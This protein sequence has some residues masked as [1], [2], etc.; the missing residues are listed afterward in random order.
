MN[1]SVKGL[2]VFKK[3]PPATPKPLVRPRK[4]VATNADYLEFLPASLE[5]IETPVS[6][7]G[8][9]LLWLLCAM[10]AAATIWS[11]IAKLDIYAVASGK[12]QPSGRSKVIQPIDPGRVIN[13]FVKNGSKVNVGDALLELDPT[14][15]KATQTSTAANL[16]AL[17]AEISRRQTE[18]NAIRSATPEPLEI[19]F[20]SKVGRALRLREA[21]LFKAELE[22]YISS[23]E[24]LKAQATQNLATKSRLISSIAAREQS[25]AVLQE[26]VDLKM[27]LLKT[28]AGTRTSALDAK[29]Q[30]SQ[31]LTS[32]A[33]D[34][35]QLLEAEA[36]IVMTERKI[37]ALQKQFIADQADK[38]SVAENKRD[39]IAQDL[40]KAVAK[41]DH[42]RLEA[43]ITGTV[44]QLAVTTVGQ[45][46]A[47][48]QPLLVIV[49]TVDHLEIEAL[50]PNEDVGFVKV[51]Q[52]AIVKIDAFP[53][54][55][56]GTIDGKVI[57][58]SHDSVY[59][60]DAQMGD[61]SSS[62]D[63]NASMLDPTPKTQNL[64][65][66]V[67]VELAGLTISVDGNDVPLVA[68]MTAKIEIRTGDRLVIDYLLSP[69]RE[70][71]SQAA[72]ER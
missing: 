2:T 19:V 7:K 21:N 15:A 62:Q 52:E 27:N 37:D 54:S 61:A 70:M 10:L 8:I 59:L 44:Q 17:D 40:I 67:T 6:P 63:Q 51:G 43:P 55:R 29:Q 16:E 26:R 48:G 33:Q 24:S 28:D 53:F 11:C 14:E 25:V 57:R 46:V 5:I 4:A 41:V 22:Q 35:G 3:T 30:L 69:L 39:G 20:P 9:V 56:Y 49:P 47:S 38:L 58:I 71:A 50:M 36:A 42:T 31:E 13:I 60:K 32:L 72:H 1:I 68:G 45:V 65:Y 12:V 23:R 66:P 64:V 18:I 34:K